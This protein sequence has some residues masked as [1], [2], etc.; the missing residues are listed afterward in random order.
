MLYPYTRERHLHLATYRQGR[1]QQ[2]GRLVWPEHLCVQ[3]VVSLVVVR[4]TGLA[5]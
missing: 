2:R 3:H 1:V 4:H 5:T